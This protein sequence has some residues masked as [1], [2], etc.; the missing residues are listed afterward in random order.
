MDVDLAYTISNA[1]L[2][3]PQPMSEAIDGEGESEDGS[4]LSPGR[5][6][7]FGPLVYRCPVMV[8]CAPSPILTHSP[9]IGGADIKLSA[10]PNVTA[11]AQ[12]AAHIK[13]AFEFG[14]T[15]LGNTAAD[16]YLNLDAYARLD[17]LLTA[18]ASA[19]ASGSVSGDPESPSSADDGT[20]T[21]DSTSTSV[22][23]G[24]SGC[25]DIST[26]L[27]VEAGAR[28]DLVFFAAGD[29]SRVVLFRKMF[30]LF[31]TCFGNGDSDLSRRGYRGEGNSRW[32]GRDLSPYGQDRR[33]LPARRS[34][35]QATAVG[36]EKV[37][38][39]I[40]E[41]LSCPTVLMGP[42]SPIVSETADGAAMR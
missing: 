28:G 17:L 32:G 19:A 29:D 35:S 27:V 12:L 24:A 21:A 40:G 39:Q 8:Q 30:S 13:P 42:L 10:S 1:Q 3:Y 26:G 18:S 9:P 5:S 36:H 41:G 7:K 25:V 37:V 2:V 16:I 23:G 4:T 11:A 15:L 6:S 14:V 33:R 31:R 20:V 34:A 22:G 38:R